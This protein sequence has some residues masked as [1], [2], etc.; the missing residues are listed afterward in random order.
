MT[1][2]LTPYKE[3]SI[4]FQNVWDASSPDRPEKL[5]Y[6]TPTGVIACVWDLYIIAFERKA[7]IDT[8]LNNP[9]GPDLD[10]YL[11]RQLNDDV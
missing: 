4:R 1:I 8:V 3:R 2:V 11:G 7:W 9:E 10:A 5:E 6:M